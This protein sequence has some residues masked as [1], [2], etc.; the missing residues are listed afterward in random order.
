[1]ERILNIVVE[2]YDD[3]TKSGSTTGDTHI[4]GGTSLAPLKATLDTSGDISKLNIDGAV[5]PTYVN[6]LEQYDLSTLLTGKTNPN[7]SSNSNALGYKMGP[8]NDGSVAPVVNVPN[9]INPAPLNQIVN[10]IPD[11]TNAVLQR[12]AFD[13]IVGDII[14]TGNSIMV[15]NAQSVSIVEGVVQG[16][17]CTSFELYYGE[18]DQTL[19]AGIGGWTNVNWNNYGDGGAIPPQ[20]IK[21]N[22]G[23]IHQLYYSTISGGKYLF[24]FKETATD[25]INI[26]SADIEGYTHDLSSWSSIDVPNADDTIEPSRVAYNNGYYYY[27]KWNAIDMSVEIKRFNIV[28]NMLNTELVHTEV[29]DDITA[30]IALISMFAIFSNDGIIHCTQYGSYSIS[31]GY[32][33]V[34]KLLYCTDGI[35]FIETN[36]NQ[37]TVNGEQVTVPD[38]YVPDVQGLHKNGDWFM[39]SVFDSRYTPVYTFISRNG[40]DWGIMYNGYSNWLYGYRRIMEDNNVVSV[41]SPPKKQL[42]GFPSYLLSESDCVGNYRYLNHDSNFNN[43]YTDQTCVDI[44]SLGEHTCNLYNDQYN[45]GDYTA[46]PTMKYLTYWDETTQTCNLRS[47]NDRINMF[48]VEAQCTAAGFTW[49]AKSGACVDIYSADN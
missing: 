4:V 19:N 6:I 23:T 36:I 7:G 12:A 35:N 3:E 44:R 34:G 38:N 27:M 5:L 41:L 15:A 21:F 25:H 9:T 30:P 28:N 33:V 20:Y 45:G 29:F 37:Y 49:D 42:E 47:F 8:A 17:D 18:W 14:V 31:T 13:D 16:S 43:I 48:T 46:Y 1:M 10:Y 32:P 26:Y 40:I 11:V 39:S 22:L 24:V 2:D